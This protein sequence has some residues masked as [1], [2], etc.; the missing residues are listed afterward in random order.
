MT[1]LCVV[2][3]TWTTTA[4][5]S[6]RRCVLYFVRGEPSQFLC[7]DQ[8]MSRNVQRTHHVAFAFNPFVPLQDAITITITL[9]NC[10]A[11]QNSW[12]KVKLSPKMSKHV[13]SPRYRHLL[14]VGKKTHKQ[15]TVLYLQ[16]N[17]LTLWKNSCTFSRDL[18]H[19]TRWTSPPFYHYWCYA[20]I[21]HNVVAAGISALIWKKWN[22]YWYALNRNAWKDNGNVLKVSF[23]IQGNVTQWKET[24]CSTPFVVTAATSLLLNWLKFI[25]K[26]FT[27]F[28]IAKL[29]DFKTMKRR[30]M[31]PGNWSLSPSANYADWSHKQIKRRWNLTALKF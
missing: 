19:E 1:K 15:V 31:N 27:F 3:R 11:N 5:F 9:K 7:R 20:V 26:A 17:T 8:R 28:L 18:V 2:W 16:N 22:S 29:E 30:T 6:V 24:E 4:N 25:R 10:Y 12:T 13:Q 14:K 21:D 23:S